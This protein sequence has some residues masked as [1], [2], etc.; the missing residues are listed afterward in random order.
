MFN[1]CLGG[2]VRVGGMCGRSVWKTWAG[3]SRN[4]TSNRRWDLLGIA[5]FYPFHR[6]KVHVPM[7]LLL[8]SATVCVKF[9]EEVHML[10]VAVMSKFIVVFIMTLQL[11]LCSVS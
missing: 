5:K 4:M 2:G 1:P 3:G 8:L 7:N 11:S 10:F 6:H 9:A